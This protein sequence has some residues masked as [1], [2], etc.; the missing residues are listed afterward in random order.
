[1]LPKISKPGV[2][3]FFYDYFYKAGKKKSTVKVPEKKP[4]FEN[5]AR[6][7]VLVLLTSL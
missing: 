3:S 1:L 5:H 2:L 4:P 7:T 6:S